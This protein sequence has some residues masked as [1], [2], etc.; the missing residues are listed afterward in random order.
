MEEHVWKARDFCA[1][2]NMLC[3][4]ISCLLAIVKLPAEYFWQNKGYMD[5]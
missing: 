1:I 2:K 3:L 5:L 4:N